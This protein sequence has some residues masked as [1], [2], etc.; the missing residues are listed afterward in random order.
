MQKLGKLWGKQIKFFPGNFHE[1]MLRR[2][3]NQV[4]NLWGQ[5]CRGQKGVKEKK[6]KDGGGDRL[7]PLNTQPGSTHQISEIPT[8]DNRL[9][10]TILN[11]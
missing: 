5:I 9:Y 2:G 6:G 11:T 4:Q 10:H 7:W 3:K 8:R 1:Q